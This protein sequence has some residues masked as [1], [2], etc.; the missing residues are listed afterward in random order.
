MEAMD[1]DAWAMDVGDGLHAAVFE[2]GGVVYTVVSDASMAVLM[3]AGG[4]LPDGPEPSLLERAR[5]AGAE[6][7]WT[8]GLG[9]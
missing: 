2:R 4:D 7:V 8:F 3:V 1:T 9:S 5:D 6:V